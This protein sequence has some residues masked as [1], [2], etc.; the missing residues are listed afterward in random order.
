MKKIILIGCG[1]FGL[2]GLFVINHSIFAE[3]SGSSPDSGVDSRI[4]T[5]YQWLVAKGANYG[6]TDAADWDSSVTYPWGT[7][8]NR[9]MEA[10]AWEPN[11][12]AGDADV[13]A[14][15]TFYAGNGNRTIKTGTMSVNT[16]SN[17]TTSVSAGYYAA[18]TLSTVDTDL[19]ADNIKS[20][21]TI[22]GV[23]GNL[24]SVGVDYSQQKDMVFDDYDDNDSTVEESTWTSIDSGNAYKDT[25]TG[26]YWSAVRTTSSTWANAPA[27]CAGTLHSLTG[28]Y[29][30]SQK[31]LMQAYID[32]IYNQAGATFTTANRF[33]SS[34]E[35]HEWGSITNAWDVKLH[36][37][38]TAGYGKA[39]AH[40]VRC[41]RR[42]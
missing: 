42:D 8:W 41:V 35:N 26:L 22:F 13:L 2:F 11:G 28:W 7:W 23:A 1:V 30:P 32:G 36:S 14:G 9:I 15:K 6:T 3:T 10:A 33:W 29:L 40:A 39:D 20:G 27:Q 37:G 38:E 24:A 5:A 4:N 17:T 19:I 12:T 16:L 25:R 21:K 18:T 34:T 31:E